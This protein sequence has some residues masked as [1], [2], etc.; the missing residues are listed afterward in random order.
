MQPSESMRQQPNSKSVTRCDNAS[1]I[2]GW[3]HTSSNSI[4]SFERSNQKP[5][6]CRFG[7]L[8]STCLKP[9]S[10]Y[11]ESTFI[12]LHLVLVT[13]VCARGF[14]LIQLTTEHY[15]W[16]LS[17]SKYSKQMLPANRA[18]SLLFWSNA[19]FKLSLIIFTTYSSW[20]MFL[21]QYQSQYKT[22]PYSRF[23]ETLVSLVSWR[24]SIKSR[25]PPKVSET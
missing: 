15:L 9:P 18:T 12:L 21:V 16:L 24:G 17:Y 11:F 8:A 20:C 1:H 14:T 3:Y 23:C 13:F 25:P 19:I 4:G 5:F 22:S 7:G 10:N 2:P 6:Y